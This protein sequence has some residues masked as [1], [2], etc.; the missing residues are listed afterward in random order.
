MAI[1]Y[2]CLECN[3][4]LSGEGASRHFAGHERVWRRREVSNGFLPRQAHE[5]PDD[6]IVQVAGRSGRLGAAALRLSLSA[7]R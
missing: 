2:K 6:G 7:R 4:V 3:I 1:K 5:D